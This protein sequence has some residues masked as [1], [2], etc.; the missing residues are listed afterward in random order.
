VAQKETIKVD[1]SR[2]YNKYSRAPKIV[3]NEEKMN[4]EEF[5]QFYHKGDYY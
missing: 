5:N 4:S 1:K 2:D 3:L